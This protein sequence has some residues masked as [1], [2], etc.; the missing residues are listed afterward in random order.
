M[1]KV[2]SF[3]QM[4]IFIRAYSNQINDM[5]VGYAD[6]RTE[7]FSEEIGEKTILMVMV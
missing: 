3:I 7:L 1:D 4:V 2:L 5:E 6:L